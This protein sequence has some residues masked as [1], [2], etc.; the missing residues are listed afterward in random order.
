MGIPFPSFQISGNVPHQRIY[1]SKYRVFEKDLET[2]VSILL[3]MSSSPLALLGL[4]TSIIVS[5]SCS[6]H[7]IREREL[8]VSLGNGGNLVCSPSTVE[9]EAKIVIQTISF[10][11]IIKSHWLS[12]LEVLNI[13]KK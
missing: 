12:R 3:L 11:F 7:F 1:S 10:V 9:I 4:R 5:I 2:P 6:V 8:S 13:K